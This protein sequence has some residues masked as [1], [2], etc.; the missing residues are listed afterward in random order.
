MSA[1]ARC[2]RRLAAGLALAAAFALGGCATTAAVEN[3]RPNVDPFEGFNRAMFAF[4]ETLDDALVRPAARAYE[5]AVP[6]LIRWMVSNF[7]ANLGDLG[8]A[9]NQLLQGKPLM[10]GSDLMRF[11]INST[12]GFG[13]IADVATDLGLERNREDFGQTLGRWG[14]ASGPYLV[15][16]VL[17]PSSV[18]DGIGLAVDWRTDLLNHAGSEGRENNLRLLRAIDTR[19][20]LLKATGVIEGAALDKYLFVRDGYLQRRRNLVW[21]GDPP[22][23]DDE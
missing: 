19:A 12:I 23:D 9:V 5:A 21:D 13:G 1:P 7:F 22:Y 15:L 14:I 6:E 2:A 17:G 18:R 8:T 16:P 11:A 3:G 4:N 10:A 20:S